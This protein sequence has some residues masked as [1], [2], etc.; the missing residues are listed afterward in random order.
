MIL[1]QITPTT[2][3]LSI[4]PTIQD[5]TTKEELNYNIVKSKNIKFDNMLKK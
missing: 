2:R 1:Y 3:H 4:K 5:T